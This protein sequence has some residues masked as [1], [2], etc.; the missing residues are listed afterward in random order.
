VSGRTILVI[1]YAVAI[2]CLLLLFDTVVT[3]ATSSVLHMTQAK[4]SQAQVVYLFGA[5]GAALGLVL[6]GFTSLGRD[7]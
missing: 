1:L 7:G 3:T 2:A 6:V 5:V 4:T